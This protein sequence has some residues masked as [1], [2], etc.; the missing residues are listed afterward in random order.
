MTRSVHERFNDILGAIETARHADARFSLA[1]SER[2]AGEA[3]LA[4]DALLH[5]LFV[6][7]E[8]VKALPR[9]VL[10]SEPDVPWRAIK[11]MRDVIGHG[12][13]RVNVRVVQA[14]VREDLTLVE[15]AIQRLKAAERWGS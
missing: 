14:T 9:E 5:N 13:H 15:S 11:G 10:E 1:D 12:Y 8:A 4:L 2:S 7:G 6:I 3:R